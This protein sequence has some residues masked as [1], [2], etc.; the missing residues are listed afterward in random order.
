[1]D[2][3]FEIVLADDCGPESSCDVLRKLKCEY[4]KLLEIVRLLNN[5]GGRA[6]RL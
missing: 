6:Q 2:R 5:G 1:M 4:S 3:D